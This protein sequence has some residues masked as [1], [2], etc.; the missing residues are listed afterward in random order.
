MAAARVDCGCKVLD[1]YAY[2]FNVIRLRSVLYGGTV[3][4]Y[5]DHNRSTYLYVGS[6]HGCFSQSFHDVMDFP[7]GLSS[8]GIFVHA[9][10]QASLCILD[11]LCEA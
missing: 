8:H 10:L 2:V 4:L 5:C 11:H 9:A 3:V 7:P 1:V 6:K